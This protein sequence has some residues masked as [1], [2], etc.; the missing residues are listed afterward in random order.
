MV[1]LSCKV[2]RGMVINAIFFKR[3]VTGVAPQDGSHSQ[4]MCTLKCS[5]YFLDLTT[6][7]LRTE[8]NS[9]SNSCSS[10]IPFLLNRSEHDLIKFIRIA[11]EFVVVQ[12]YYERNFV[13]VFS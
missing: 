5:S 7:F 8:I 2:S 9:S 13:S 10:H 1:S 4:L 6:A 3:I 12:L 11:Q